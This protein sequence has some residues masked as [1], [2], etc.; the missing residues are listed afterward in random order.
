ML[1]NHGVVIASENLF[2]AFK[3]FETLEYGARIE[4]NALQIGEPKSL[5]AEDFRVARRTQFPPELDDYEAHVPSSFEKKERAA[6]CAMA[7]RAYRQR[8]FSSTQG[9]FSARVDADTFIIT[10]FDEDRMYLEPNDIVAIHKGKRERGKTPSRSVKIHQA[11]YE[12]HSGV[13]SV[14]IAYPHYFMAFAVTEA[15]FDSRTIPESYI[16]LR[17]VPR[18]PFGVTYENPGQIAEIINESVPVVML[19]NS[20]IV[21]T[22]A[23]QLQAFD[24][25]EVAEFSARAL[26]MTKRLGKVV[27][28]SEVQVREI[29]ESFGLK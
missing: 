19:Q 17:D 20:G 8:L 7:L 5:S 21:A 13:N 12:K 1:E 15:V 9:T 24:R 6:M 26:I 16:M 25:L 14:I 29:N 3:I 10:P 2:E 22:G 18:V 11:I 4:I 27:K 23:S 28:I